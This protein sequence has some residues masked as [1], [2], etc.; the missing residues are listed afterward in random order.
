[1][2]RT[3]FDE[4]FIDTPNLSRVNEP[5][6]NPV[7]RLL[8]LLQQFWE[9][10]DTIPNGQVLSRYLNIET[11]PSPQL[12]LAL[13]ALVNL[14]GEARAAFGRA[15][16]TDSMPFAEPMQEFEKAE[17]AVLEMTNL[18]NSCQGVKRIIDAGTLMA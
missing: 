3:L 8:L 5:K 9:A 7:G 16:L 15:N 17:R 10:S 6:G 14:P 11:T 4:K 13:S 12:Y 1:M 2:A 18:G